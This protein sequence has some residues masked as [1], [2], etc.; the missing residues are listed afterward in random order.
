M[1]TSVFGYHGG[2]GSGGSVWLTAGT[3]QGTGMISANGGSTSSDD[4]GGGGGGGRIAVYY[5]QLNGF[6]LT[7]QLSAAGGG[8]F[9]SYN[10]NGSAGTVYYSSTLVAPAVVSA[11]PNG[12]AA[13]PLASHVDLVFNV[14]IDPTTFTTANVTVTT[15][16]GV[17]PA[18]QLTV[19]NTGG[20]QW[21]ISFPKQ[22][23]NGHYQ[24]Q[25]GPHI[26]NLS[27]AEMA[28][29]YAGSFD[30]GQTSWPATMQLNGTL[31]SPVCAMP[32]LAGMCYQ[33][34]WSTNLVNWQAFGAALPG[35]GATLTW[36]L[37]TSGASEFYRMQ[38]SETP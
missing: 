7:N 35:N 2:A 20:T 14:A 22:T 8:P 11:T 12:G 33:L 25:V 15:P 24:Y 19:V 17:I 6:N 23:A 18:A 4:D 30:I 34:L 36:N 32:S 3:L 29:A 9:D 5:T 1:S 26:A 27:G 21:R 28:A 13:R 31:G 38:V 16:S 10:L 37:P